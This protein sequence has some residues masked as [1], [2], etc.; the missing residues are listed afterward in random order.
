MMSPY[1]SGADRSLH[2][3][4][5]MHRAVLSR[6]RPGFTS[7]VSDK[8]RVEFMPACAFDSTDFFS[9]C[10]GDDPYG[11]IL[12]LTLPEKELNGKCGS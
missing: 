3:A 11:S 4:R 1:V 2:R 7:A 9:Q 5:K 8:F 6:L 10:E 12:P